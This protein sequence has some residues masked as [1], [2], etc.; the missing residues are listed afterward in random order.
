VCES[1]TREI[2]ADPGFDLGADDYIRKPFNPWEVIA[3]IKAIF[4]RVEGQWPRAAPGQCLTG[5]GYKVEV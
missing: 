1:R 4:R 3:C 2:P 5:V